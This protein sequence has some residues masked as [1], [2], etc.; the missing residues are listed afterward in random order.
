MQGGQ[1]Q[2]KQRRKYVAQPDSDEERTELDD[3]SQLK[4]VSHKPHFDLENLCENVKNNADLS[5]LK[6]IGFDKLRREEKNQVE[7]HCIL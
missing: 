6:H 3:V 5:S 2:K 4:V 7:G 1:V